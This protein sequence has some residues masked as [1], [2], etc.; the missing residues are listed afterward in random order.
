ML[1]GLPKNQHDL[2][3]NI[4][5]TD[6][7]KQ[8]KNNNTSKYHPNSHL[9]PPASIN[10]HAEPA[11]YEYTI[12]NPTIKYLNVHNNIFMSDFYLYEHNIK[13]IKVNKIGPKSLSVDIPQ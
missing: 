5:H 12:I 9:T 6:E 1:L 11:Q 4:G 2:P 13:K 3:V 7:I 8:F 10:P